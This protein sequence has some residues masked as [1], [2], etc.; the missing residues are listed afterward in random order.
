MVPPKVVDFPSLS[1]SRALL[2]AAIGD[3]PVIVNDIIT[4]A[5]GHSITPLHGKGYGKSNC[6]VAY[7]SLFGVALVVD[8]NGIIKLV[9]CD[10]TNTNWTVRVMNIHKL[11][12]KGDDWRASSIAISA[13]GMR[14]LV[15][16]RCGTLIVA[17]F[18]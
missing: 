11:H 7:S 17:E 13:D 5:T 10:T 12:V 15:V 16:D 6:R 4:Q 3:Y 9:N 18:R 14:G 1:N 8:R 2:V